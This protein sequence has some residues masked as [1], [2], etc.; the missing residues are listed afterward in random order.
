M[1]GWMNMFCVCLLPALH[2]KGGEIIQDSFKSQ[3]SASIH[4]VTLFA[5]SRIQARRGWQTVFPLAYLPYPY[6]H[7]P[8]LK[9]Y[10]MTKAGWSERHV[11]WEAFEK[12]LTEAY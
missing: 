4:I 10:I 2:S 1:D 6:T 9:A 3:D 12:V 11:E 5:K 7:G 8:S